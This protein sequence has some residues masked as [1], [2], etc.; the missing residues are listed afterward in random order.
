MKITIIG[1]G[2]A[3]LTTALALNKLGFQFEVY[4]R[5]K[6]LNE[7]GAGIWMQ[8][9]A[10]KVLDWLG[11]GTLVRESG[12]LLDQVDITNSQLVPFKK[13]GQQVVQDEKGNK[14]VAIHRSTLQMILFEALP[15]DKV[16]L[17]YE[18]NS[19]D[20]SNNQLKIYIGDKETVTDLLIGADGINSKVRDSIFSNTSKRFSGQTC[21]RGI[22]EIGLPKEFQNSGIESWGRKIR[23]GFSQISE[24]QVYWF[25]VVK[26][27]QNGTDNIDSIKSE[28]RQ[29]YSSFHPLVLKIIDQTKAEKIIRNDISD[30]KRLDKWHKDKV[31]L[32][33]DAAHATTPNMGQGAGQG[34]EDAYY[35]ANILAGN[36]QIEQTLDLFESARREKVDYVVN[37]SWRLGQLAHSDF[38]QFIMKSIMKLTPEK[39]MKQ[40]MKKL[41]LIHDTF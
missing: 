37:N 32:V 22:S 20:Y 38:G 23:F 11:L 28:L 10:L 27:K 29:L 30:L 2:I 4:E 3:G 15:K 33:G 14:I 13:T 31:V 17:G 41:Y 6:Q 1:G 36:N 5:A 35:L 40:Q 7:V 12:T 24:N 26:A 34:I 18:F 21:W 8:P 16:K 19:I 9:N 39:V 25:A